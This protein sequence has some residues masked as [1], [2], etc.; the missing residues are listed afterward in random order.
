M[1]QFWFCKTQNFWRWMIV[2][3]ALMLRH[4][5]PLNYAEKWLRWYILCYVFST[6]KKNLLK[7]KAW[8]L[9]CPG[10][11]GKCVQLKTGQF[12]N[13]P[14]CFSD[15]QGKNWSGFSQ[16]WQISAFLKYSKRINRKR[17]TKQ[18][19]EVHLIMQRSYDLN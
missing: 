3:A 4:L 9:E 14:L 12:V 18:L 8:K 7:K 5:M 17:K 1:G 15:Y 16:S 13:I 6:I 2:I 19:D 11:D 10:L